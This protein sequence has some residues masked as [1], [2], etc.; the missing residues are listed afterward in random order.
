MR[1]P[2]LVT[3]L[4]RNLFFSFILIG[5]GPTSLL[6][7]IS[8]L[9][10]SPAANSPTKKLRGSVIDANEPRYPRPIIGLNSL[11]NLATAIL[12]LLTDVQPKCIFYPLYDIPRLIISIYIIYSP[13]VKSTDKSTI[14]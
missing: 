13:A 2:S 10:R 3:Q 11:S 4:S 9:T 7:F 14:E 8:H 6:P 12:H 5:G 1:P